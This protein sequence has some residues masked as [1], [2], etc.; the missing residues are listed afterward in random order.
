MREDFLHY[1]WKNYKLKGK[2]LSTHQGELIEVLH[3]GT[4]NKLAGPDF[5]NAKLR[6]GGQLWAGN[7]EIHIKSSDWYLHSHENDVNYDNVILHVVWEHN[8]DVY[9]KD[10]SIIPVLEVADLVPF[11]LQKYYNDLVYTSIGKF[12]NCENDISQIDDFLWENW[13]ERLYISRLE[14]KHLEIANLLKG[15][16]NNWEKVLFIMLMKNFGLNING[17]KFYQFAKGVPFSVVRKVS[18][19]PSQLEA[20]LFGGLGLLAGDSKDDYQRS[21]L[22]EYKFLKQKFNLEIETGQKVD[23]FGLRP[24]NFPTIRLAQI[25]ALYCT[26]QNLFSVLM[27]L[28]TIEELYPLFKVNTSTYWDN[29]YSFGKESAYKKKTVSNSFISLLVIN[30]LIPLKFSYQKSKGKLDVEELLQWVMKLPEE[31]NSVTKGFKAIGKQVKNAM[32]S[33]GVLELKKNYCDKNQCLQCTIG[34]KLLNRIK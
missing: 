21:L 32:Q 11:S 13:L 27:G 28:S 9:R 15:N 23:F 33:Q 20:L 34:G 4:H 2:T 29:H 22:Q 8:V 7:V 10:G 19:Y 31:K 3:L 16:Q 1:V 14:K 12:I 25:T 6:I 17:P 5:F 24:M 18:N 26:H 30:T